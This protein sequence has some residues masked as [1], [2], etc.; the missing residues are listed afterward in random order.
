M[1]VYEKEQRYSIYK[2]I[3]SA[4]L[5]NHHK[6]MKAKDIRDFMK[7]KLG[8]PTPSDCIALRQENFQEVPPLVFFSWNQSKIKHTHGGR[9]LENLGDMLNSYCECVEK[10]GYKRV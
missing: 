2:V 7:K 9:G 1:L 5:S 8:K 3:D 6:N 10:L 4:Y